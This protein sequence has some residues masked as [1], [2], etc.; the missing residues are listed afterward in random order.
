MTNTP[1]PKSKIQNKEN[2]RPTAAGFLWAKDERD[3][4]EKQRKPNAKATQGAA[5]CYPPP[6]WL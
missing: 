4:R 1:H 6:P 2:Q 3:Q 5:V